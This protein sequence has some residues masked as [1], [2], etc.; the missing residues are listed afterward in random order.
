MKISEE[1][2][3]K[4]SE[5]ILAYLFSINPKPV[6]TKDIAKEVARDEEFSKKLLLSLKKKGF[7]KEIKSNPKGIPYSKRSRWV[8]TDETY[9]IYRKLNI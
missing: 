8:L 5:Q 7:V 9:T 2:K 3:E 6:F 1:K 4:I